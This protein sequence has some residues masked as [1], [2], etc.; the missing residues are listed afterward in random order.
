MDAS[1]HTLRFASSPRALAALSVVLLHLLAGGLLLKPQ[2]LPKVEPRR[3]ELRWVSIK[4]LPLPLPVPVPAPRMSSQPQ[5]RQANAAPLLA[6]TPA[7]NAITLPAPPPAQAEALTAP[8]SPA[9]PA[10][11]APA[12]LNLKLPSG[13][14]RRDLPLSP[15]AQANLDARA[16]SPRESAEERMANAMGAKGWTKVEDVQGGTMMRGPHG[17][18][19]LSR[20][21][22][23]NEIPDHPHAGLVM[24][25]VSNCAE[26]QKGARIHK[27]PGS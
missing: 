24:N 15:A 6:K 1:V 2:L 23:V 22:M 27:R 4:P 12:P 20:P 14:S 26:L 16:N 9:I 3:S 11:A 8:P 21:S 13:M 19:F 25:K 7:R 18:C 17:E 10:S 5:P